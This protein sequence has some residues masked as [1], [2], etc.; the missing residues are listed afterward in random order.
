M[1]KIKQ[2]TFVLF[3]FSVLAFSYPVTQVFAQ[4]G[5]QCDPNP[6]C[7]PTSGSCCNQCDPNPACVIGD[8]HAI[9]CCG[10]DSM[11]GQHQDPNGQHQDPNGQHQDPNGQH[12]DPNGQHQD[13]NGQHQDPNGQHQDP[14]GQ[15][16]DPNGQHQDPN[17]QHQDPNGQHQDP[18]GQHQDPN[19]Q[20]Q[21]PNGQHQDPNGQHQDPNGQHQDPNGQHQDPNGQHQ[22]PNG[23]GDHA[24]HCV[25]MGMADGSP[26]VDPPQNVLDQVQAEYKANCQAGNCFLGEGNYQLLEGM[27]HTREKIDCF[28]K[29]GEDQ[30]NQQ[31]GGDPNQGISA[32]Q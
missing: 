29:A 2:L 32:A 16:Q 8:P 18:N 17:G 19:G 9:P 27:G 22:D 7:D 10:H 30:H 28:L 31:H 15:H 21:D 23:H 13:P 1:K 24:P 14:N 3:I 20:H 12:Q 26:H 11:G 6:A 25:A 5:G 4:G